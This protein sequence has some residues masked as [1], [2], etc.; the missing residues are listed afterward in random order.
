VLSRKTKTNLDKKWLKGQCPIC[1][2]EYKYLPDHKPITC[3][4]F[5]CLSAMAIDNP[6]EPEEKKE[7]KSE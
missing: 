6:T 4:K 3:G 7:D 5:E 2:E 1:G